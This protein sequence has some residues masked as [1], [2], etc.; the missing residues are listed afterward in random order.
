[1]AAANKQAKDI[2]ANLKLMF[3][4]GEHVLCVRCFEKDGNVR[5]GYWDNFRALALFMGGEK[6]GWEWDTG[7]IVA[8]FI[9]SNPPDAAKV[10]VTNRVDAGAQSLR[11]TGVAYRHNL[12]IDIDTIKRVDIEIAKLPAAKDTKEAADARKAEVDALHLLYG[13]V[14]TAEEK[15]ASAA[16]RDL[17]IEYLL[18]Q[19]FPRPLVFCSGNGW[20][21]IYRLDKLPT[22]KE[23]QSIIERVQRHLKN[24]FSVPGVCKIDVFK[25]PNRMTRMYGTFNRKGICPE[26]REYWQS[27]LVGAPDVVEAVSLEALKS[28][29]AFVPDIIE[30]VSNKIKAGGSDV[31]G[32]MVE[33]C[34]TE[35]TD[36]GEIEGFE[37]GGNDIWNLYSCNKEW[38]KEHTS[39]PSPTTIQVSLIDGVIGFNDLRASCQSD[40][41]TGRK[42]TWIDFR[43]ACDPDR[44]LYVFPIEQIEDEELFA[45]MDV[46]VDDADEP[47]ENVPAAVRVEPVIEAPVAATDTVADEPAAPEP[48]VAS[49]PVREPESLDVETDSAVA[50]LVMLLVTGSA[51]WDTVVRHRSR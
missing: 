6:P 22:D 21:L 39:V 37:E 25:D 40:K 5:S 48:E 11:A 7:E 8:T 23:H 38:E 33:E 30:H 17:I 12:L 26:G 4:E 29:A 36:A 24:H 46:D 16:V 15:A 42:R 20:H 3:T 19:G 51:D 13:D 1:M 49:T 47:E 10:V 50:D 32:W 35:F 28:V 14:A 31:E 45:G 27:G 43:N 18:D 34:L 44:E 9:C 2:Y 41:E